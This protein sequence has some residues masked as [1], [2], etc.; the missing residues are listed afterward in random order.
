[1]SLLRIL[2][3]LFE[4]AVRPPNGATRLFASCSELFGLFPFSVGIAS[5]SEYWSIGRRFTSTEAQAKSGRGT[6]RSRPPVGQVDNLQCRSKETQ[7]HS[8]RPRP[9]LA[10]DANARIAHERVYRAAKGHS[11]CEQVLA[12]AR[13]PPS[14]DLGKPHFQEAVHRRQ[15]H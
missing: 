12:G 1:M 7:H 6:S 15:Q 5:A 10:S 3:D 9:S 4:S 8:A 14:R 11:R 13:V 2:V